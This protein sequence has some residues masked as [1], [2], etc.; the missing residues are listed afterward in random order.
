MLTILI[1]S[2]HDFKTLEEACELGVCAIQIR[3]KQ[4]DMAYASK[5]CALAHNFGVKVIVNERTDIALA[6][7]ADG[8]HLPERGLPPHAVKALRHSLLV[9]VS[10]HSI[11]KAQQA[12][13]EGADSLLFG[14]IFETASKPGM[15]PQGLPQLANI[16]KKVSI[17]V[18]AVGGISHFNYQQCLDAGAK[19]VA[20]ISCMLS[21]LR[22]RCT[23]SR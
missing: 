4:I 22:S 12:E 15:V 1:T 10:V 19:G 8:V 16:V 6:I 7:Q 13:N 18:Y 5:V 14:P 2:G 3:E 23:V 11:Q 20:G 17:P 21:I 9:G